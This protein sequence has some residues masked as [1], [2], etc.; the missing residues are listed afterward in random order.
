[1]ALQLYSDK[2]QVTHKGKSLHPVRAS[3]MNVRYKT[4]VKNY[5]T[6]A[7][8]PIYKKD[9]LMNDNTQRLVKL[10]M[11]SKCLN[12]LLKPMKEASHTGTCS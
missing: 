1:V 12:L 11:Y 3:L 6:V 4:R 10:S 8:F 2:T 7:Y 5:C 9:A